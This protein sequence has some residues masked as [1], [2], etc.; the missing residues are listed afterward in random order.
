MTN[1][2]KI[3]IRQMSFDDLPAVAELDNELYPIEGG[4]PLFQFEE[5]FEIPESYWLIA[6]D[7]DLI[8]G[9]AAACIIDGIGEIIAVTV[10]PEYRGQKLGSKLFDML[11]DWMGNIEIVLQVR[12]DNYMAIDMYIKRGFNKTNILKDYY[13]DGLNAIEMK[14][15]SYEQD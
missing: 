5:Y 15:Y 2:K 10:I 3:I 11:M 8:V 7:N 14:K 6:E 1:S 13:Q 9:Y 4:W 12:E